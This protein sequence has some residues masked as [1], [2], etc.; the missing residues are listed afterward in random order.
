MPCTTMAIYLYRNPE[1]LLIAST[2]YAGLPSRVEPWDPASKGNEDD[3][4]SFW[5]KH[6]MIV[7]E[8]PQGALDHDPSYWIRL[9]PVPK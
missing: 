5:A 3:V 8:K 6:A 2:A 7:D 9:E 1:N 4:V